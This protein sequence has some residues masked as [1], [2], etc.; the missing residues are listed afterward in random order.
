MPDYNLEN[1]L[2]SVSKLLRYKLLQDHWLDYAHDPTPQVPSRGCRQFQSYTSF[3]TSKKL[4]H[5]YLENE[6]L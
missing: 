4:A 3:L 6:Q 1:T 2:S 5:L